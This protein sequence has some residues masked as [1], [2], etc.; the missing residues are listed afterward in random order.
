VFTAVPHCR[1]ARLFGRWGESISK[2]VSCVARHCIDR[3]LLSEEGLVNG[4]EISPHPGYLGGRSPNYWCAL[5]A[6]VD[7]ADL[8]VCV[9][10]G[11]VPTQTANLIWPLK[12][13]AT[14]SK[15]HLFSGP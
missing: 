2:F 6:H 7:A 14:V 4:E 1:V 12:F 11:Y 5:T 10:A 8:A 3:G 13:L 15:I 9:L